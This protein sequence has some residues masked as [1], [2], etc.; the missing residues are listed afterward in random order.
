MISN[1]KGMEIAI[2][3]VVGMILGALML[4]AGIALLANV[5]RQT[6]ETYEEITARM[7]DEIE[8]AHTSNDPIYIHRRS[9]T[10]S[11]SDD[12][13][14]FGIS[15]LNVFDQ[16]R[17]FSVEL[18]YD[19]NKFDDGSST[20]E[21]FPLSREFELNPTQ[22]EVYFV[23]APTKNLPRGQHSITLRISYENDTGDLVQ[24]DTPK[25][26]YVNK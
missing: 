26:L 5:M 20:V 11:S 22:R 1:K 7:R 6:D 8:K 19:Q 3:T 4:F 10:V 16:Q 18:E 13:V 2:S 12:D 17:N 21:F 23:I 14:F 15:V 25:M 9:I 24:Y